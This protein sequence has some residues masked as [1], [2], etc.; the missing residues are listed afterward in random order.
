MQQ[1]RLHYFW[2]PLLTLC[3]LG[4]G[5]QTEK[6]ADYFIF[7]GGAETVG[8]SCVELVIN[9]YHDLVDIGAEYADELDTGYTYDTHSTSCK[10]SYGAL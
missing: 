3:V 4:L 9:G 10:K 6:T 1:K 8:G 5:C 2:L 7:H